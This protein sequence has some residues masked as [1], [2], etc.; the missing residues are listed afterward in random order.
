MIY[1]EFVFIIGGVFNIINLY[2]LDSVIGYM[3]FYCSYK[4]VKGLIIVVYLENWVVV[5]I[6]LFLGIVF[7]VF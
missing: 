2:L 4:R 7:F 3:V 1:K 5:S 6:V